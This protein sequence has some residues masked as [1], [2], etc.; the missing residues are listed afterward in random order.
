MWPFRRCER[1]AELI[2]HL[3]QERDQADDAYGELVQQTAAAKK[4]MHEMQKA[5]TEGGL[6]EIAASVTANIADIYA[7]GSP[8]VSERDA[9]VH[10][11]V[12]GAVR[13]ATLGE[14]HWNER[15]LARAAQKAGAK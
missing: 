2:R 8:S 11:V 7:S 4:A 9:A 5:T 10:A 6:A 1:D 3:R 13:R 14:N 12:A 15:S